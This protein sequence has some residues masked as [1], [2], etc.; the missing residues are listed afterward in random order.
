MRP[1]S[2][3]SNIQTFT[4]IGAALT[5]PLFGAVVDFT[6]YRRA[7]GIVTAFVMVAIQAIQIYTVPA[8]WLPMLI[9]QAVAVV[10]YY[11]QLVSLYAYLPEMERDVGQNKMAGFTGNFQTVQFGSQAAFLVVIAII[12]FVTKSDAVLTAQISQGINTATCLI[13]FSIGWFKYLGSRNA[14]RKLPKGHSLLLEGFRNN[15]KTMLRIHRHFKKGIRWFFLALAFGQAAAQAITTLSSIYLADAL[16]LDSLMTSLFFLDVLV[17]SL[18]G[19]RIGAKVAQKTNPNISYALS[20]AYLFI[21]L[22]IGLLT[23]TPNSPL[24]GVF[25]WGGFVGIGLGWLYAV[26]PLYL[27]CLIPEGQEC[28]ISGFYNFVTVI[29][30]WAP[31]VV[32]SVCVEN[33]VAQKYAL[34]AAVGFFV[35]AIALLMCSGK[36]EDVL[37]E[38]KTGAV[39]GATAV[40]KVGENEEHA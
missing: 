2:W 15:F 3:V 21:A 6:D 5:M 27:S 26:E 16:L 22:L 19:C 28:E 24:Y 30:A 39:D 29:L 17:V 25:I 32:F 23:L 1:A 37:A 4:S 9:L 31:P 34:I 12:V 14:V 11:A 13:F 38:T 33:D 18:V 36:W 8:T 7:S 40:T 10:F 20:Y 35:P